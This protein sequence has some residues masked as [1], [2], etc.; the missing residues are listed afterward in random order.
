MQGSKLYVGNLNYSVTNEQLEEL[1]SGH[2]EVKSVNVIVPLRAFDSPILPEQTL[3]RGLRKLMPES[4]LIDEHLIVIDH[5]RFRQLWDAEI[6]KGEI[7]ADIVSVKHAYEPPTLVQVDPE[8]LEYDIEFPVLEG[9]ITT[10]A[11]DLSKLDL[12]ELPHN[13]F[14]LA[15]VKVPKLKYKEKDLLTQ[16]TV[17]EKTLA[18]D[19]T[20]NLSLYLSYIAKAVFAKV[21]CLA[22]FP[23]L[24]VK[25]K[26]YIAKYLFE[27][28][29]DPTEREVRKK[30]NNLAVRAKLLDMFA[31][32]V[33]ELAKAT[34]PTNLLRYFRVSSIL[35]FHTSQETIEVDKCV[36]DQLPYPRAST[37][38]RDFIKWLDEKDEVLA[39]TKVLTTF[40]L[41]IPYHNHEGYLS[42]YLPDFIVKTENV[43]YLIE[44]KGIEDLN[45]PLKDAAATEWCKRASELTDTE[46]RYVKVT[47]DAFQQLRGQSFGALMQYCAGILAN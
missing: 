10:V 2:G 5:P 20:E 35:P 23:E 31:D 38:E 19:Y 22:A 9:G 44:T 36:F 3:G 12:D 41:Y 26:E 37:M 11:P 39:F 40:P 6:E 24:V 29:I 47:Y 17:R 28:E 7:V 21:R 15:D 4:P 43:M 25:L 27:G 46:W 32:K 45:V 8:K 16:E 18:F 1:F 42:Y 14:R 30:L 13:L 34:E 33:N